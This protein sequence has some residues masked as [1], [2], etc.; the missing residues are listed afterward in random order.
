MC[1]QMVQ[2]NLFFVI[3]PLGDLVV[4]KT[5]QELS[6]NIVNK[7]AFVDLVELDMI[8]F[9][10]ISGMGFLHACFSCIDCKTRVVKFNFPN[11]HIL[12][13][14]GETQCNAPKKT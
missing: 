10:V 9:D 11:E 6:R 13:W 1:Y 8:D 2:V 12:E 4:A 3:S 7:V 14:K 5:V